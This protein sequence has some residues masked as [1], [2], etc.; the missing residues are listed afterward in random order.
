M[1][2]LGLARAFRREG[3]AP[4]QRA[5]EARLP[6]PPEGSFLSRSGQGAKKAYAG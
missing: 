2:G 1:S 4:H 5:R 3:D 6:E